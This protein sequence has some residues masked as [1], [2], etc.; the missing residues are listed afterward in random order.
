MSDGRMM[1]SGFTIARNVVDLG[2]PLIE[3]VCSALPICDEFVISEGYSTDRTRD[4]IYRDQ[5]DQE[6]KAANHA[7][8]LAGRDP[9]QFWNLMAPFFNLRSAEQNDVDVRREHSRVVPL[10]TRGPAIMDGLGETWEFSLE[11]SLNRLDALS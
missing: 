5:W 3:S 11:Q 6:W 7:A 9:A 10:E 1:I 2:Y 4:G 8:N